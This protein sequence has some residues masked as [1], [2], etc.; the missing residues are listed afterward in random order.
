MR[1]IHL[2]ALVGVRASVQN[3]A[4]YEDVN[5]RGTRNLLDHARQGGVE[6]FVFASS[7]SVYGN[8]VKSPSRESDDF[9]PPAS[10]YAAS[11]R[12][13]EQL[14]R[15]FHDRFGIPTT[16]VRLFSVY[17]PRQRPDMA[18]HTFARLIRQNRA[19]PMFGDGTTARDYTY[20]DDIL[21]GLLAAVDKAFAFEVFNLGNARA[22][23]LSELIAT[24]QSLHGKKIPIDRRPP[25]A[26]DVE[27]TCADITKARTLL[28]YNPATDIRDGLAKFIEWFDKEGWIADSPITRS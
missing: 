3:P 28:G 4:N 15:T 7:S 17:G 11:K 12:S 22:I 10:P 24:L 18:I 9:G 16:V 13:G 14:C 19:I 26:G 8:G 2:A 5:V 27:R 25:Q 6:Q 1:V 23:P 20:I 21:R